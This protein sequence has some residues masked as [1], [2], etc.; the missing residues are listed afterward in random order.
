MGPAA[1]AHRP[2]G[3]A[4][5]SPTAQSPGTNRYH[6]CNGTVQPAPGGNTP[7]D[8]ERH[9][10]EPKADAAPKAAGSIWARISERTARTLS[11]GSLDKARRDLSESTQR[12]VS[13]LAQLEGAYQRHL[14]FRSHIKVLQTSLNDANAR[15]DLLQKQQQERVTAELADRILRERAELAW[16]PAIAA[17]PCQY[18]HQAVLDSIQQIAVG[19]TAGTDMD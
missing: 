1:P 6:G 5:S 8:Q 10:N 15:I 12:E 17:M 11:I 16:Q 13:L 7:A 14:K 9:V 18:H 3:G 19:T 4:P 2:G